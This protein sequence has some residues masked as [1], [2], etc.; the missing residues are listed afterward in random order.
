[1]EERK[2]LN[3]LKQ[4]GL[5]LNSPLLQDGLV[6]SVGRD[7]KPLRML[8][9][10]Y[11]PNRIRCAVC[12]T[13]KKHNSG[14]TLEFADGAKALSGLTCARKFF[15]HDQISII[16]SRFK[17][18]EAEVVLRALV[19]PSLDAVQHARANI[20]PS[21]LALEKNF[22]DLATGLPKSIGYE[23]FNKFRHDLA[24]TGRLADLFDRQFASLKFCCDGLKDIENTLR[25]NP[26]KLDIEKCNRRRLTIAE[27]LEDRSI[28]FAK[29]RPFSDQRTISVINK[30]AQAN[31]ARC[32]FVLEAKGA[33]SSFL[34]LRRAG[35]SDGKEK[36]FN[37][38]FPDD[39][40]VL[41]EVANTLKLSSR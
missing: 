14:V 41:R 4:A 22:A 6:N 19:G 16:E 31:G 23:T 11:S 38:T 40:S 35:Q 33:G 26:S 36:V 3:S 28:Y 37:L 2:D 27:K 25:S 30:W 21:W 15:G 34:H 5:R 10:Y 1:M 7:M 24:E 39:P 9:R 18:R 29:L 12:G 20:D 13:D 32:D 17:D 8:N